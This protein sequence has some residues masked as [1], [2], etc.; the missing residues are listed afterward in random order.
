MSTMP[1]R[2]WLV[3]VLLLIPVGSRPVEA[4]DRV[5]EDLEPRIIGAAGTT[6]VGFSGY[7]DKFFSPETGLPTN[8]TVQVDVNHFLTNKWVVRGG[9]AGSGSYGGDDSDEL[10][11]GPGAPAVHAL[12][13]VFFYF[14]PRSIWSVY[15]GIGLAVQVTQRS[16]SGMSSLIGSLGL[17]GAVSSRASLFVEGGFGRGLNKDDEGDR[18]SRFVGSIGIRL[19]L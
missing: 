1:N 17:Q 13:G 3:L 12:G 19:K 4:Q 8:Y 18:L 5:S 16:G 6:V 2:S 15:T 10:S 14:T 9:L 7:V 11:T